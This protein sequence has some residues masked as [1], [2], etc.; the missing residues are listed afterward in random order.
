MKKL[1]TIAMTSAVLLAPNLAQADDQLAEAICGYIE[2]DNKSRLRKVL[3]EN[4]LRIRNIH[5]SVLCDG[6]S[7]LRFAISSHANAVGGL[8]VSKLPVKALSEPGA[9]GK[10]LN[11][12]AQEFGH[13]G[14]PI[15]ASA[16]DKIGG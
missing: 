6:Q 10:T 8:I 11:Q 14:S 16:N 12:W 3:K 7:M 2:V 9:D 13:S 15:V 4:K 5:D 1:L